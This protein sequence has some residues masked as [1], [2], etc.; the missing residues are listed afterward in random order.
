MNRILLCLSLLVPSLALAHDPATPPSDLYPLI[1][2]AVGGN[3]YSSVHSDDYDIARDPNEVMKKPLKDGA[4]VTF[5]SKE[6]MTFVAPADPSLNPPVWSGPTDQQQMYGAFGAYLPDGT[7]LPIKVPGPFI[8]VV[9]GNSVV[10]TLKNDATSKMHHSID[11]HSVVGLKG[12]AAMLMAAPGASAELTITP[13]HPGLFVYHCAEMGTPA[14]IAEHMNMGM[15]GLMLVVDRDRDNE[16]NRLLENSQEFYVMENDHY[17]DHH[18]EFDE[19]RM[20][21]TMVPNVVTYN[22]R[23]GALVDRPLIATKGRNAVIYHGSSGGHL[24]SFHI[25]GAIFDKT[26]LNGDIL[27]P[28]SRNLQTVPIPSAGAAVMVIKGNN[29]IPN[30]GPPLNLMELDI[31]VDHASPYFRKGALGLMLVK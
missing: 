5:V 1:S 24:P 13:R 21:N 3:S 17:I 31:L 6:I 4:R 7:L 27:I 19:L 18:G 10:V 2:P 12:G 8:K 9:A 22:G 15:F 29:L 30:V 26:F 23:V 11:F 16:L 20:L 25:I 14:G 28:P